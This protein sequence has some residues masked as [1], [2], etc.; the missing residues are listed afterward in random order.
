MS[1]RAVEL[2]TSLQLQTHPEGGWYRRVYSDAEQVCVNGLL[3]PA[4]TA[5]LY[6][7]RAGECGQWHRI[8]A[9]ERWAWREG[10]GLE[11]L[12]F[13]PARK[14]AGFLQRLH[15]APDTM[16]TVPAGAWQLARPLGEFVLVECT[17]TP[18]FVWE[19]FELLDPQ[20][21]LTDWL[22]E[23]ETAESNRSGA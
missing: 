7:L 3:R 20:A 10:A 4:R 6:L 19:G 15:L 5:I 23:Q 1:A 12:Q 21:P 17:V 9:E 22:R 8:D 16:H 2:I 14:G 18:G 13:D 11:L